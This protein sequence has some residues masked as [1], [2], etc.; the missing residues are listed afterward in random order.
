MERALRAA[1]RGRHCQKGKVAQIWQSNLGHLEN[2]G[3]WT[4][5]FLGALTQF[6][7]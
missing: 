5:L 7:K 3:L 4:A 1:K 6:T 2:V